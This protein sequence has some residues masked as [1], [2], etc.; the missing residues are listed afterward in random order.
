[1]FGR[2]FEKLKTNSALNAVYRVKHNLKWLKI[3]W[4]GLVL[5]G[6]T[7]RNNIVAACCSSAG[8]PAGVCPA[9]FRALVQRRAGVLPATAPRPERAAMWYKSNVFVVDITLFQRALRVSGGLLVFTS[10]RSYAFNISNTPT[11]LPLAITLRTNICVALV[12]HPPQTSH[13]YWRTTDAR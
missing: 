9:F 6:L 10:M 7:C 2:N 8:R 12:H 4:R 13:E 5:Q 11:Q 1:M 3:K